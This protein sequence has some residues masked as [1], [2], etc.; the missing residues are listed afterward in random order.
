MATFDAPPAQPSVRAARDAG[1]SEVKNSEVK[2]LESQVRELRALVE[3]FQQI[4]QIPM[5]MHPGAEQGLS[6]ELSGIYQRLTGQGV[7]PQLA[8]FILRKA[9]KRW[10]PS[11]SR[12]RLWSMRGSCAIY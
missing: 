11:R 7:Q 1:T 2:A 4:P 12:S 8:T 10:T 6:F 5:T 9:Q 3:R